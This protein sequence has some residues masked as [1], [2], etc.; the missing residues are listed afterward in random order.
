MVAVG[1]PAAAAAALVR[2]DGDSATVV[3]VSAASSVDA[4]GARR[5]RTARVAASANLR[6]PAAAPFETSR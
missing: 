6:C 2:C 4:A 1:R 3:S 5:L